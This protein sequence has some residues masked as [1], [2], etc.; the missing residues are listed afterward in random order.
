MSLRLVLIAVLLVV[1][2]CGQGAVTPGK[3]TPETAASDDTAMPPDFAGEISYGNGSVAPPYHYEWR[4]EFDTRTARLTWTPGY[5]D[6]ETW[7]EAVDLDA[8][9]RE[10]LY[11]RLRDAGLF[12]FT[13]DPDDGLVGGSTGQATLRRG[14]DV[15]YDSGTL[16]TSEAGQDLLD[17]VVAATEDLFPDEVWAAMDQR[18]R[19]WGARQPK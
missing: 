4:V 11:D 5:E 8:A 6:A 1:A 15:F 2:G 18:Q 3:P 13:N 16:G 17:E 12:E 7:T 14:P 9:A 19:D 10:R